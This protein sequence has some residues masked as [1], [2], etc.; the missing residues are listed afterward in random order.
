VEYNEEI[1]D[2]PMATLSQSSTSLCQ[3]LMNR[4]VLAILALAVV[5]SFPSSARTAMPPCDYAIVVSKKTHDDPAWSKV[6]AALEKKY[7][8]KYHPQVVEF[9]GDVN[10]SLPALKKLFP[11][12]ACFVV[13]PDE[14]GREF[15]I[16]V[17]RL[18]RKLDDDPYTDVIWGILTGYSAEDALRIAARSEPLE[19]HRGGG[20]TGFELDLFDEGFIVHLGREDEYTEKSKGGKPEKR[21]GAVDAAK[22]TVDLF[23]QYKPQL[24]ISS[25]HATWMDLQLGYPPHKRGQLRCKDGVLYGVDLKGNRYPLRSP[26]PKV[27]LPAGNCLM[28][29]IRDKQSMA[30]AW[31]GS[32]GVDQMIG[33]VVSTWYGRGGGGT[34]KYF[35][36]EPG[37]YTLSDAFYFNNQS[38]TWQLQTRFAKTAN[39]DFNQWNI[40]TDPSIMGRLAAQLGYQRA[41]PQT[42]ENLGLHWDHDTVAFYG[43]PAWEARL[44]PQ[45]AKFTQQL[46]IDGDRY[47]FTLKASDDCEPGRPPAVFLPRRVKDIKILAGQELKPLVTSK[48]IMVMEPGTLH[49]GKTCQVVFTAKE[50]DCSASVVEQ[51]FESEIERSEAFVPQ[52][53]RKAVAGQLARAGAN[54]SQLIEALQDVPEHQREGLA[55]LIANMPQEDLESLSKD[56]LLTNLKYAYQARAG[57]AWGGEIPEEIFLN[58]VLPYASINEHRDNWRKDFY[59]RFL[60]AVKHC[61]TPGEAAILLNKEAFRQLDVHYNRQREKPDQSPYESARSKKATCSGLSIL[62]VDAFRA[63]AVPARFV[64]VP[65][66]TGGRGNHSWTEVWDG[67]W[68][69]INAAGSIELD[70]A[71]FTAK[72]AEADGS[73]PENRIYA[74]S[75]A[76]TG[77]A[78]LLPWAPWL[79]TVPAIDV[80][81]LYKARR[82]VSVSI[83]GS[84]GKPAAADVTLRLGGHLVAA[85]RGKSS[86]EFTLAGGQTYDAELKADGKTHTEKV[87]VGND[88]NKPVELKLPRGR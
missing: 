79:K 13:Q 74:A 17:H 10:E 31:L 12:Y 51:L 27:Y 32:G 6:V 84:D 57:V 39:V 14:A 65:L 35:F 7:A 28:G 62:A 72:A 82:S 5:A 2:L 83:V 36:S 77:T 53:Y 33:Y 56:F 81:A 69:V 88:G 16:N 86:Y 68:H 29:L 66:W 9:Q 78:F 75:F 11:R 64:G 25:G 50:I 37:R 76:P 8:A 59:D 20:N 60:P 48:F 21:H 63:V 23:A 30:V 80:T 54:G 47:T 85:G 87:A 45:P 19:V 4:A 73:R 22:P 26:E 44:A 46:R 43:D 15:V 49:K 41:E 3:K 18:T 40:E 34:R 42:K 61:K 52:K 24:F 38:I 71:W 55:F 70:H 67:S 1:V 58:D